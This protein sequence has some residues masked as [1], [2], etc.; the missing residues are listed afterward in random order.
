MSITIMDKQSNPTPPI[1]YNTPLLSSSPLIK[2]E[3]SDL[4]SISNP[5]AAN[6][7]IK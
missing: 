2:K 5:T 6:K 1:P 3:T 4:I 7:Q